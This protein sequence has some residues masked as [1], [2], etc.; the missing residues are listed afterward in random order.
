MDWNQ[1]GQ[2]I[3][4]GSVTLSYFVGNYARRNIPITCVDWRRKEWQSVKESLWDEIKV[5][6]YVCWCISF[7]I[8]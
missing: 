6:L 8:K 4:Q 3:G 7:S 1:L 2:P 5:G